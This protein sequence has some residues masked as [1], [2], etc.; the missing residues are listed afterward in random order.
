MKPTWGPLLMGDD[1]APACRDQRGDVMRG[2][3]RVLVLLG[4]RASLAVEDERIAADRHDRPSFH[5]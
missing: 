4:D 1:D 2:L 3:A 5:G